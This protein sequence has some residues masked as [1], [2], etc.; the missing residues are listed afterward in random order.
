ML[1]AT[2]DPTFI[3]SVTSGLTTGLTDIASGIGTAV[4]SVLPI[5]LPVAGGILVIF[6]G[7]KVFKR[8]AK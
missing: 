2:G 4:S 5:A 3:E 8:I 6:L 1:M 7:W